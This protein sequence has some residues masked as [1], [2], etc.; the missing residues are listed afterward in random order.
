MKRSRQQYTQLYKELS[1]NSPTLRNLPAAFCTGGAI[2]ALGQGLLTLY[3]RLGLDKTAASGAVSITLIFLGVTLTALGL[4]E[5]LARFAGAGT[6]VPI[7]GFANSVAAPALEF[8]REGV[9]LGIGAKLFTLSGPVLVYGVSAAT[10]Y[11]V[12]CY[13]AAV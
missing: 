10:L 1:P 8:R 7:T 11:G 5:K 2:C 6:L 9:I 12:I 13:F 3:L 4:F